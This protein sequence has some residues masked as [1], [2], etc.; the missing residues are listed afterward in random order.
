MEEWL[1]ILLRIIGTMIGLA[2]LV[3]VYAAPQLVKK[4]KLDEKK[5][6]DPERLAVLDESEIAKYK[7]DTAV[8]DIKL[9]GLIL[10]MPGF[11]LLLILFKL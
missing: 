9:K 6:I 7:F 5:S 11:V 3:V 10:A 4:Y 1:D 8:L 2:G